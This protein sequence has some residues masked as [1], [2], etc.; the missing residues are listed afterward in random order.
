MKCQY[1]VY[2]LGPMFSTN[3]GESL[4]VKRKTLIKSQHC[5]LAFCPPWV[6]S[7]L[8]SC[9][10]CH[11]VLPKTWGSMTRDWTLQNPYWVLGVTCSF[12]ESW[13]ISVCRIF[14]SV[15]VTSSP[16][17]SWGFVPTDLRWG[18]KIQSHAWT[19]EVPELCISGDLE[20]AAEL[21]SHDSMF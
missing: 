11:N 17:C 7:L 13:L 18:D 8:T 1:I 12:S 16:D 6:E 10:G 5:L 2:N 9:L 21:G 14:L 20:T 4:L 15:A 19:D 3:L